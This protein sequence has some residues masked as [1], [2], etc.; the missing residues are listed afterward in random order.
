M[1]TRWNISNGALQSLNTRNR[2]LFGWYRSHQPGYT[3]VTNFCS[4]ISIQQNIARFD[5]AAHSL[6]PKVIV[7]V[8]QCA[9][10]I[11]GYVDYLFSIKAIP[12]CMLPTLV[13][14][15]FQASIAHELIN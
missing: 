5:V 11:N 6:P 7:H 4:H 9:G 15:V 13:D 1:S 8:L 10:S 3:K 12:I 2:L 14:P